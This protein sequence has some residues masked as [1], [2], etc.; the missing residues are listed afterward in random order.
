MKQFTIDPNDAL[1]ATRDLP[2]GATVPESLPDAKETKIRPSAAGGAGGENARLLF[3]GTAT[4]VLDHFDEHVEASLRR[5]LPIITTPH[6]KS[7]LASASKDP[8]DA[9]TA[10][11]DLDFF[12]DCLVNIAGKD[13]AIRVTGMPG[14]HVPP[15]PGGVAGMVNDLLGTVPP[16]NGWM[17]EL[18]RM[19]PPSSSPPNF[20][21][22]Y[23]IYISGDTLLIPEL[24][25]IPSRYPN[26]DL[27]L[28]HLGGT[29]I[30]SPHVPLLMVTMDARQGVELVRLIGPEVTIPVHFDLLRSDLRMPVGLNG[31]LTNTIACSDYDVFLSPLSDFKTAMQEAGFGDKVVYLDRGDVYGFRVGE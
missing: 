15:G 20:H 24:A 18:G 29:T 26:I 12:D 9:F 23:R 3:V 8:S 31:L 1:P 2:R 22:S 6:A 19:I 7:H 11:T 16:T 21:P 25:D 4:V 27:M 10:V 5:D 17:L 14:K 13:A 28:V 30:P